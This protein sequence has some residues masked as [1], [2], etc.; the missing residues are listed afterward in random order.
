MVFNDSTDSDKNKR[1]RKNA[2]PNKSKQQ[3]IINTGHNTTYKMHDNRRTFQTQQ[4]KAQITAS[5]T[6]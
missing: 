3:N 2:Q 6:F 5:L 1:Y 4:M